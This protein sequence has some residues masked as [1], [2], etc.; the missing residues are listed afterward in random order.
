MKSS[1]NH[2]N[3]FP[4]CNTVL[5]SLGSSFYEMKLEVISF[6]WVK[7]LNVS[8]LQIVVKYSKKECGGCPPI[9]ANIVNKCVST[10]GCVNSPAWNL[11]TRWIK[12]RPNV[13]SI[14]MSSALWE[15]IDSRNVL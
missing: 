13:K 9:A 5:R 15:N 14:V 2:V 11:K 1:R 4:N 12:T 7:E 8:R 3:N 10:I 6:L